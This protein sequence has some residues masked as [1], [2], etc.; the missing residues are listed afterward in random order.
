MCGVPTRKGASLQL[1]SAPVP[2]PKDGGDLKTC[3][4]VRK[5]ASTSDFAKIFESHLRG[6]VTEDLGNKINI[7]QFAG[8]KGMGTEHLVVKLLD[9]VLGMLDKPGMRAVLQASVDWASAFSR[10]DPTKTV[11]KM[12]NMGIR[13]SIVSILIEFLEDRQMTV[14]FN[15]EVSSLFSLV[16]GGP[17]G[18]WSGQ[19]SYIISSDD[20]AD[21]VPEDDQYKYCDDLSILELLLLGDALTEYNFW[22]HVASD[23]GVDQKFLPTQRLDTQTRLDNIASW[24]VD[25]L[26]RLKESKSNYIIFTR[27]RQDFATRLSVNGELVE[28]KKY[29][30]LLGLWLQEDGGWAKNVKESCKRAYMRMSFLSK[31]RYAG[32]SRQELLHN[33]KQFIRTTLEY[34]SVAFHSSLT[35]DQSNK[36]EQCQAVALRIILQDEYLSYESAL[37]LS[38]LEKLSTRRQSRCLDFSLKCIK[39]EQNNR[40]FPTNPNMGSTTAVRY[41]EPFVVNFARTRKYQD[42][43]IPFCQRLLNS[44]FRESGGVP[45]GEPG[46]AGAELGARGRRAGAGG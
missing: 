35:E 37:V 2:K 6:W 28:R 14:K 19:Q 46:G 13:P 10:T 5:V 45:G 24:T 29:V 18:S 34:C 4:D 36:L 17:Q 32:I 40:F 38:G 30:K 42:S 11:T 39:H 44:H 15:T 3:D 41:R 31:L 26:M 1:S 12:I 43:A 16:G 7:N 27:S 8:R 33:Y 9:R 23:V 21:C 22:E 25:N 20:N